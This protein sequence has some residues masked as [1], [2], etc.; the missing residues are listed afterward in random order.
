M[1]RVALRLLPFM[2]KSGLLKLLLGGRLHAL[3]HG[4]V[5]V[6]LVV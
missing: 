4:V 2:V 3:Q 1:S 5:P 6:R